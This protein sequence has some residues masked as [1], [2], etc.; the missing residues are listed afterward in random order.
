[1][2]P[3]KEK[4]YQKSAALK[5]KI[6][7]KSTFPTGSGPE[8]AENHRSPKENDSPGRPPD[9][10]GGG[11]TRGRWR[12]LGGSLKALLHSPQEGTPWITLCQIYG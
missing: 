10:A 8:S 1:M 4:F 5:V 6:T 12:R 7:S 11:G 9:P 2:D 3:L